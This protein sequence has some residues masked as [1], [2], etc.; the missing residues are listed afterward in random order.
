M[1]LDNFN[2]CQQAIQIKKTTEANFLMLGQYLHNI[3]EQQLYQ[4]QWDSFP[5]Y[6]EDMTLPEGTAS[7]LINIYKKFVYEYGIANERLLETGGWTKLALLLPIVT[8]KDTAEEWLDKATV[9]SSRDLQKEIKES[10]TGIDMIQCQHTKTRFVEKC[11]E[12]GE[13]WQVYG[14]LQREKNIHEAG[15]T[16]GEEHEE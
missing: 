11:E 2:Y 6:L 15:C 7:K 5:E 13:H 4:G 1:E 8:D 9:L 12:C 16:D 10:E 14:T 3:R